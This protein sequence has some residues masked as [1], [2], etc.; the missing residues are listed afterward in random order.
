MVGA[1]FETITPFDLLSFVCFNLKKKSC[2]NY[3]PVKDPKSFRSRA[4]SP[5]A[6][7]GYLVQ[8]SF[9]GKLDLHR[10]NEGGDDDD[11]GGSG[12]AAAALRLLRD[13][14]SGASSGSTASTPLVV[15][16]LVAPDQRVA[17]AAAVHLMS[18]AGGVVAGHAFLHGRLDETTRKGREGTTED[19]AAAAVSDE[20]DD[21]SSATIASILA[22]AE[23]ATVDSSRAASAAA[24]PG[25]TSTSA[26]SSSAASA[27]TA[28]AAASPSSPFFGASSGRATCVSPTFAEWGPWGECC[29][30]GAKSRC[31]VFCGEPGA[32]RGRRRDI[33][34]MP[35]MNDP[36][37]LPCLEPMSE[38]ED[39]CAAA[40]CQPPEPPKQ[41]AGGDCP[42]VGATVSYPQSKKYANTL[43]PTNLKFFDDPCGH[44][45][46]IT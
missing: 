24:R 5:R 2:A 26:P 37:R 36:N 45:S 43:V 28:A 27:A 25:P 17:A 7:Q 41:C 22:A 39:T 42:G 20:A 15:L 3:A 10:R 23:A 32:S 18:R 34:R 1:F 29:T 11:D 8:G 4:V 9:K 14:S 19:G 16:A 31:G 21:G 46:G 35:P 40:P 38:V 30:P 44:A 6:G 13:R 12:D 33:L